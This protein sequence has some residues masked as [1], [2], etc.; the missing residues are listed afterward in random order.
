[1]NDRRAVEILTSLV[2]GTDPFTGSDLPS[3]TVLQNADVI[4]AMLAG[5]TALEERTVRAN[6]R[7]QLPKNI[8]KE[9]TPEEHERMVKAFRRGDTPEQ[10]AT[11]HGRT[12]RA[13]EARLEL[14]GLITKQQRT[15]ADR[16]GAGQT[17]KVKP[18]SV[19][20]RRRKK[21]AA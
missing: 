21:A 13:I 7:A 20:K 16:F 2:N 12:P 8:G 1:M 18:A 17:S 6:R 14:H 15:T 9:W 3:G 4:R 19:G 11:D 5:G 10:I